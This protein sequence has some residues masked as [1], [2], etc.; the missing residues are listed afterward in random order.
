VDR[1]QRR[2]GYG[3]L[4]RTLGRPELVAEYFGRWGPS[5]VV[6]YEVPNM[7]ALNFGLRT[8]WPAGRRGSLRTDTKG[9]DGWALSRCKMQVRDAFALEANAAMRWAGTR[10]FGRAQ[11]RKNRSC[12]APRSWLIGQL[13]G[14]GGFK[15]LAWALVCWRGLDDR[16]PRPNG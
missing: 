6:R 8:C 4:A 15:S 3:W 2:E 11:P 14:R 12:F 5:E 13:L 10:R 7:L 1:L 16:R 9:Q